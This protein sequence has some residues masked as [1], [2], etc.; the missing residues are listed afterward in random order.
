MRLGGLSA[1]PSG[2]TELRGVLGA[3]RALKHHNMIIG[4][5]RGSRTVIRVARGEWTLN[6]F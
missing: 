2:K 6:S 5:A 1:G 3:V 4:I